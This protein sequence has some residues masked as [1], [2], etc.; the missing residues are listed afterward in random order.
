MDKLASGADGNETYAHFINDAAGTYTLCMELGIAG[1]GDDDL[2]K[3]IEKRR[4]RSEAEKKREATKEE[5]EE[6][7][8]EAGE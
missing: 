4:T 8:H 5:A 1:E 3:Y 2:Q 7:N 6:K